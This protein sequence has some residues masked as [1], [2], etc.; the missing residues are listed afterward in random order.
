MKNA[1]QLV[2][3]GLF[4]SVL[5]VSGFL[6]WVELTSSFDTNPEYL[7][8]VLIGATVGL[9]LSIRVP[10]NSIGILLLV[11]ILA[12][13]G[14]GAGD[15]MMA[16]GAANGY[17]TL[18]IVASLVND[19][20]WAVLMVS[21]FVLLPI[22]FPD[23][24][25][26]NRWSQWVARSAIIVAGLGIAGFWFAEEVCTS[27][28]AEECL[29][30]EPNPWGIPGWDGTLLEPL[31]LVAILLTIPAMISATIRWR[32]SSGARRQQL[33]WFVFAA[34]A[35][36]LLL[37]LTLIWPPSQTV[38]D[39]AAVLMYC[40]LWLSIGFAVLRY[41]LYDLDRIISRTVSYTLLVLA[42]GAG[43]S[44][45]TWLPSFVVGGINE[46][47]TTGSTPPVIVAASTLAVAAL[48]NPLRK[49]VQRRVDRSFNRSSY[50]AEAI[51]EGFSAKL[52]ASL[53]VEEVA[54]VW[55]QTVQEALQPDAAAVWINKTST[56]RSRPD[57]DPT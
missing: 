24:T 16:W 23:G 35:T 48:F 9:V 46:D 55:T 33:K 31:L 56:T 49:R 1:R 47:G 45:L 6:V 29:R 42:L 54:E 22:W 17:L 8:P 4:V 5:V 25:P 19:T 7:I 11:A 32:R 30:Y 20:S 44:V 36:I 14:L 41:R 34:S 38:A 27:W 57:R 21:A 53:T 40:S 50:Q 3:V 15:V 51:A 13:T 26:I 18:S 12:M 28:P 52:Q 43:F 37:L 10:E 2:G 39:I